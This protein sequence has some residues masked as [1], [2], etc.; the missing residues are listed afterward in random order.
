MPVLTPVNVGIFK[1]QAFVIFTAVYH[2][3]QGV[4]RCDIKIAPFNPNVQ[5]F[6]VFLLQGF[7]IVLIQGTFE[8]GFCD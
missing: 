5:I 6:P 7:S 4:F 1:K 3:I 2:Q 8:Q